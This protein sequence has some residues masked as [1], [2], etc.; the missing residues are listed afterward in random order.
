MISLAK[1]GDRQA[2]QYILD[3]NG[4]AAKQEIELNNKVIEVSIND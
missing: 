1:N 2:A 4:Y 3:S